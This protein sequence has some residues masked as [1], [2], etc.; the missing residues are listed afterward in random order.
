[1]AIDIG[2]LYQRIGLKERRIAD[3]RQIIAVHTHHLASYERALPIV[4]SIA[5]VK[6]VM[7]EEAMALR[8]WH[9]MALNVTKGVIDI[10]TAEIESCRA[11]ISELQTQVSAAMPLRAPGGCRS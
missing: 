4:E 5:P 8:Y 3:L 1:M 11:E 6:Q 2:A 9:E 10:H 7:T